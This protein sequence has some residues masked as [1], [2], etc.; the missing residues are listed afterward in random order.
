M[1]ILLKHKPN[2]NLQKY[3]KIEKL[4]SMQYFRQYYLAISY[5]LKRVS[6]AGTS[7]SI[8][9]SKLKVGSWCHSHGAWHGATLCFQAL[10]CQSMKKL[11]PWQ[12]KIIIIYVKLL[13]F[14]KI[15][16]ACYIVNQYKFYYLFACW[17]HKIMQNVRCNVLYFTVVMDILKLTCIVLILNFIL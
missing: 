17:L 7:R 8:V 2:A 4:M 10:Q 5:S 1:R 15:I 14:V 3:S 9:W 6:T 12:T 16:F 13:Y 11:D